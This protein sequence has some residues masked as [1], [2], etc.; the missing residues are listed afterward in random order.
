MESLFIHTVTLQ[1]VGVNDTKLPFTAGTVIFTVG[2]TVTGGTS[3]AT[4]V[5]KSKTVSSGTWVLGTAVGYLVLYSV[6]GTFRN[7]ETI[8]DN[9]TVPG[10]ATG[11]TPT[12]NTDDYGVPS[13]TRTSTVVRGRVKPAMPMVDHS[14]GERIL[15]KPTLTVLPSVTVAVEDVVTFDGT[16]Y[17]VTSVRPAYDG[18][19]HHH[20]V[21][22]LESI[23]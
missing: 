22:E 5:I 1:G 20:T 7:G 19:G 13:V 8:T 14:S 11:G 2:K 16:T 10:S 4:G 6:S 21:C 9:G 12:T 3:H 17:R 15:Q 23:S 18:V